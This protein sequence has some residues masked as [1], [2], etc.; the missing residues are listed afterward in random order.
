MTEHTTQRVVLPIQGMHCAACVTRLEKVLG[1]VAGVTS[2]HV[3]LATE[4]AQIDSDSP[5]P[6]ADLIAVVDKAG[7]SVPQRVVTL[8]IK[9]M[10]CAAC[11]TR[12]EKVLRREPGVISAVVNLATEKAR[13]QAVVDVTDAQLLQAISRA[14]YEGLLPDN[15]NAAAA[16]QDKNKR[17]TDRDWLIAGGLCTI[18]LLLPMLAGLWGAQFQ[19]PVFWQW[20]LASLV[21][22]GLGWRF[23]RG[24]W[25]ALRVG[26]SNMDVLV[27]LGTTAAYGLSLY[28]WLFQAHHAHLYFESSATVI[29]LVWFGKWLEQR[30]KRQTSEAIRALQALR[31][32]QA[33]VERDGQAQWLALALLQLGDRVRVRAGERIPV[34]G[35]IVDGASHLDESLL[36]GE[37]LPVSKQTGDSVSTGAMNG[38]GLL[39]LKTTALGENTLLARIIAR[40]EQAQMA[41]PPIQQ[42]VDQISAVF[43]PIV[44]VLA[45]LTVTGWY[46]FT[47]LGE[48]AL[49]HAVSVLVI[50]CPCALGLAT[51]AAIMAGT[52]TAARHGILIRDAEVLEKAEKVNMVVFD[53][54]GTLTQGHPALCAQQ[55]VGIS[56][57]QALLLAAALQQGSAHP[58]GVA[59][60]N[61]AQQQALDLPTLSEV[62]TT[63]GIGVQ[64]QWQNV[65]YA[66][67][68]GQGLIQRQLTPESTLQAGVVLQYQ[69]GRTVS[70]LIAGEQ[71]VAWFAFQDPPKAEAAAA[72]K[73]LQ[74]QGIKVAL[75]S[76]DHQQSVQQMADL[77]GIDEMAAQVLPEQKA[78]AI[79]RWREQGFVV[80]MVG[81]GINDAPA[82]AESD[83]G[84]AMGSGTDVAMASAAMTLMRN[85]PR[86]VADALVIARLTSRKIRQNLFW[87]F[88]YNVVALPLAV[89]GFLDP[90]LAGAAMA[91]SSVSVVTNALWLTRWQPKWAIG[92]AGL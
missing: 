48:P 44:L 49:I 5:L 77:L 41:K 10:H 61:A 32:E 67:V 86:A 43:V 75:L 12:L 50:A 83:L 24:A 18:P 13:I 55:A 22:F 88:I 4:K 29:T 81:D 69:Q 34:D 73:T 3:N 64:G 65:T 85:D 53:K 28:Q 23:Y 78:E 26:S 7:F 76:G 46:L 36:T 38:E 54:T 68:G 52:G 70:W 9:G 14:G 92:K 57:Q 40:V 21:Q 60:Q 25:A 19:L 15:N 31:P 35:V 79:V 72:I 27:A 59:L 17:D 58:L 56:E 1:K 90:M 30:A 2:A 42:K 87:A 33:W 39:W 82:L 20:L 51:P 63:A 91:F 11:V 37:S 84:I 16:T 62:S 89:L 45:L 47:G 80:A 6:V 71:V 8:Q 74:Q 66:L